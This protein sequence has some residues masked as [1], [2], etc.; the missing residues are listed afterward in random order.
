MPQAPPRQC[1]RGWVLG[2]PP[3][4]R[5]CST[6]CSPGP[7]CPPWQGS[8]E[9]RASQPLLPL[10]RCFTLTSVH[11]RGPL[12]PTVPQGCQGKAGRLNTELGLPQAGFSTTPSLSCPHTGHHW[13]Q[14]TCTKLS[15]ARAAQSR[16]SLHG[17]VLPSVHSH[18]SACGKSQEN[19]DSF[20]GSLSL[21]HC[22]LC[23]WQRPPESKE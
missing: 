9:P 23:C 22:K 8:T 20:L 16:D 3:A 14:S 15:A 6:L 21:I 13:T 10:P 11:L 1:T 19:R 2:T 7:L 18:G 5:L 12:L 4:A 17:K